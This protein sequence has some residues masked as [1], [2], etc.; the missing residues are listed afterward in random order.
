MKISGIY[1]NPSRLNVVNSQ[2]ENSKT[3]YSTLPINRTTAQEIFRQKRTDNV[4]AI[5]KLNKECVKLT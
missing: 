5:Q 3:K 2:Q 4:D 1:Y